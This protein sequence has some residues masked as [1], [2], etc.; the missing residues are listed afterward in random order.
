MMGP[1]LGLSLSTDLM[2]PMPS[3]LSAYTYSIN[4]INASNLWCCFGGLEN[5]TSAEATRVCKTLEL[6]MRTWSNIHPD[7]RVVRIHSDMG[8]EFK[9]HFEKW[10]NDLGARKTGTGGYNS[11]QNPLG[12]LFNR[13]GQEGMRA[14]LSQAT[15][16]DPYYFKSLWLLALKQAAYWLN[17]SDS[18]TRKSPW[19]ISWGTPYEIDSRDHI[20]G[21]R[22]YYKLNKNTLIEPKGD[23]RGDPAIWVGRDLNTG[24]HWVVPITWNSDEHRFNLFQPKSVQT[25]HIVP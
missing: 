16:C 4:L 15:G 23:S 2:G 25:L 24:G 21:E 22:C 11:I 9:S 8:G 13:L 7:P 3:E 1:G 14:L 12:E 19:E 10:C 5:K 18:K 6:E 17:R 20:F